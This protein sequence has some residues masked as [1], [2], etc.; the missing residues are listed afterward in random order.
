MRVLSEKLVKYMEKMNIISKEDEKI[1]L[2]GCNVLL[3]NII[4]AYFLLMQG[5]IAKRITESLIFLVMFCSIR[6]F[7]GGIHASTSFKCL[8]Y[9]NLVF[10]L[11]FI[12][13][14]PILEK[15]GENLWG[16][17]CSVGVILLV[18]VPVIDCDVTWKAGI[19]TEKWGK[20]ARRIIIFWGIL[21]FIISCTTI[22]G[23]NVLMALLALAYINNIILVIS[24]Y[25][26]TTYV[27]KMTID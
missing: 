16:I 24:A 21:V 10:A 11:D 18:I 6:A 9:S 1:Y 25:L 5:I 4:T 13:L 17:I 26:K 14:F 20:Q 22:R 12:I 3:S 27:K 15:N 19:E 23:K 2:F 7:S 8:V